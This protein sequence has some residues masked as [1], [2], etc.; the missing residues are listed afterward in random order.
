M[1][2]RDCIINRIVTG[3]FQQTFSRDSSSHPRQSFAARA[4]AKPPPAPSPRAARPPFPAPTTARSTAGGPPGSPGPIPSRDTSRARL[5][6]GGGASPPG[7]ARKVV[8]QGDGGGRAAGRTGPAA[9]KRLPRRSPSLP[10]APHGAYRRHRPAAPGQVA[11]PRR[12]G[13][14]SGG[15]DRGCSPRPARLRRPRLGELRRETALP[16]GPQSRSGLRG[17]RQL[18]TPHSGGGRGTG[19]HHPQ[20]RRRLGS[21]HLLRRRLCAARRPRRSASP[22]VRG[23][24]R[25]GLEG[26]PPRPPWGPGHLEAGGRKGASANCQSRARAREREREGARGAAPHGSARPRVQSGTTGS[27]RPE[28]PVTGPGTAR[29]RVQSACPAAERAAAGGARRAEESG[30]KRPPARR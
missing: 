3:R 24:G 29:E 12:A 22:M 19:P 18:A 8:T 13:P 15:C 5:R 4:S 14:R 26:R 17:R 7:R 11:P 6:S 2:S 23:G 21:P 20:T 25:R 27:A 9:P 10:P 30:G 28:A 16:H 1:E